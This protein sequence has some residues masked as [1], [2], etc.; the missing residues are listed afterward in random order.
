M[1]M[2]NPIIK[3]NFKKCKG[4]HFIHLN[5]RSI[6]SK[7]K[8]ENLKIQILESEAHIITISE[9]WLVDKCDSKLINIPGYTFIRLDRN[10]T[11]DGVNTKKGGGL[12]IYIKN[13]IDYNDSV[14]KNNNTSTSDIE[15]QWLEIKVK[16][17]KKIILVNIYRPPS[18]IY[19]NFCSKIYD[20]LTNSVIKDN[21]D[22]F[23]MGDMNIDMLDLNSPLKK[24]LDN[25]MRRLG[26]ININKSFTRHSKNRNSCI[27]L[28]FSNSDCIESHGLLDWNIS[29][30]MG[31]F[32]TRKRKKMVNKKVHFTGRS[33]KN[34]I[35]EDFQWE[36]INE[37]W[38]EFY[39]MKNVNDAWLFMKNII[40]AKLDVMCPI[41]N[42]K[43]NEHRDAW[44]T[45]ELL[46]RIIDKNNLLAKARKSG[47]EEDWNFARISR[48][49]VNLELSNAKKEFLLYEQK[50]FSNDPKKFWQSI[51]R[52]IPNKKEKNKDIQL[53][54]E[55]GKDIVYEKTANYT[56]EFFTNIG[57]N[58]AE[59]IDDT[60]WNYL[61]KKVENEIDPIQTDFEE[62]LQICK[63]ID[64]T[65]SSG[66]DFLSSK[67]LKDAFMVLVTQL[68]YLF[69][70]SLYSSDF[71][72]NWKLATIIP[73]FKGGNSKS[74][75]NYRPVSLLPLPGKLMEKIVH[76]GITTYL[77]SNNLLSDNQSGFRKNYST[78]KSI[79]D[80][81]DIIF[82]NMNNSQI[83]AAVF[84]D[85]R[86][87]FD[88]VNHTILLNKLRKMGIS[89]NLFQWCGNYLSNRKQKTL[90]NGIGSDYHNILCGVPQGSV[91]GPL[92]F[93]IYV[94][95][96]VNRIG[97]E[98]IQLYADDTVIFI[99]GKEECEIQDKLQFL[100]NIF[101]HWCKENKLS[102]NADKTKFVCFGTKQRIKKCRNIKVALLNTFIQQVPS[103]KY[104]GV[105]LD[106]NL[107]FNLQI[108]M[109]YKKVSHKLYVLS[110]IR[111]FL[112]TK[113]AILIYKSMILPYFD[114]GD[115]IYMFS[116]KNELD[117]LERL[118]ERCIN[119]CTRTYGRD[120]IDN[121]RII[122]KL[123]TLE[124]RRNCHINNFMY[125]RNVNIEKNDDNS[126]QTRSK[127]SKKFIIKKPNLEAYKRSVVYSGASR[128][129]SLKPETKNVDIYEA[130]KYHQKREM[131]SF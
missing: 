32:I 62:V 127:S 33:Y 80:F 22:I 103:Y 111:Q 27:D 113:S 60:Y 71:P 42:F 118:Q 3:N 92:F 9:T 83:T 70:L 34:Y 55:K 31:I 94:N 77:E 2:D 59:K 73:L 44:I 58:L 85:L 21:S 48:N 130:F 106:S 43:V 128:W 29:D 97:K 74:V 116:S 107:T 81:N 84:I 12:G 53:K 100:L 25:T 79:V 50:N 24:E 69:N 23:I 57:K 122:H 8:F 99:E 86:K 49:I 109:T 19:K 72:S 5:V 123:P 1:I 40:I 88:T 65:K 51:S 36:I 129:N 91:L 114:Y 28:I 6:L 45:N 68:V 39:K 104:L 76:R 102:I 108:Q 105:S 112:N 67:I 26:L 11:D 82:E 7:G 61:E 20:S 18:G 101:S 121:I 98:H 117:K 90:V 13:G 63:D 35:K 95:D 4:L 120:N 10:W 41:K 17:M 46:E 75:S 38:D 125:K 14:L 89:D 96:I 54:D 93:L 16:N 119:I 15:M 115:I 78:T 131:L 47:K 124:R 56:N 52:I 126:I 37:N 64:I 87:A 30:H 66:I 110:K